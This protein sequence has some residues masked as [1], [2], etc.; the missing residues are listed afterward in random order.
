VALC[1]RELNHSCHENT[2]HAVPG[3]GTASGY[4]CLV[5]LIGTL[6]AARYQ[7]FERLAA[8]PESDVLP[9]TPSP[10]AL[11]LPL[12]NFAHAMSREKVDERPYGGQHAATGR[13]HNLDL[14]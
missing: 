14:A 2:A 4:P 3:C 7:F 11:D 12:R 5:S 9:L 1:S 8:R 13:K 6:L 10:M